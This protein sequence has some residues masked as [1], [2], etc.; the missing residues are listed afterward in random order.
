VKVVVGSVE[1]I[2]DR[3]ITAR[4]G[5]RPRG[6]AVLP[7]AVLSWEL[8]SSPR[9]GMSLLVLEHGPFASIPVEASGA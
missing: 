4:I 5:D 6:G 3:Q 1:L 9:D 2:R 8:D 7:L